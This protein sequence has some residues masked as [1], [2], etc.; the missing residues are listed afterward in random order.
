MS[1]SRILA[2]TAAV[3]LAG[4]LTAHAQQVSEKKA[5]P[6]PKFITTEEIDAARVN[7]AY[8]VVEKLHPEWLRRAAQFNTLG[9]GRPPAPTG[10][11]AGGASGDPNASPVSESDQNY[12][13]ANPDRNQ[14][15]IIVDGTD[16]GGTEEL[17]QIQTNL[18]QEMRYLTASDAGAKYGPRYPAGV[19]EVKLKSR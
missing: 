9:G 11:S 15:A 5:T 10:R 16:M 3:A 19:I 2:V 1:T 6:N 7:N 12:I 8:Q 4:A 13:Q 18:I 14:L 17:A